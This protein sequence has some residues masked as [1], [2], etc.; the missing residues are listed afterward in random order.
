MT[1]RVKKMGPP[2]AGYVLDKGTESYFQEAQDLADEGRFYE[3]MAAWR[4]YTTHALSSQEPTYLLADKMIRDLRRFLDRMFSIASTL[5]PNKA[6]QEAL[7]E[8]QNIRD[9]NNEMAAGLAAIKPN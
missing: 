1:I 2:P 5:A 6:L 4:K 3:A 9:N 8:L 7:A